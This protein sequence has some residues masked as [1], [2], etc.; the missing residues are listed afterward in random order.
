VH[1]RLP[2]ILC[3]APYTDWS[4]HSARQ[5]TILQGLRQRGCSVSYVTC[6]GVFSDCDLLQASTGAPALRPANA[7]LFCQARVATRLAGWGMPFRWLSNWLTSD[8]RKIAAEWVQSLEPLGYI[9]ARYKDWDIGEWVRSSVHRHFRFNTLD[10]SDP[11]VAVVF[12]S[13]LYSGLLACVGLDR[14]FEEEKPDAQL[15]FNGRMAPTRIA[16]ELAKRRKIR[17]ICEERG[18]VPNRLQ[19]FHNANC[20]DVRDIAELWA[21]WQ[22]VP[23]SISE[24]DEIGRILE[25]R[26]H[27]RSKDVTMFSSGL[28]AR[29]E[30]WKTLQLDPSRPLY[31]LFSSSL[32]EAVELDTSLNSFPSQFAW[33][34]A[35]VKYALKHPEIQLVIRVHPNA[36]SRKSLGFN[37]QDGAYFEGLSR[38]LPANVR[39]VSGESKISS[40][41][42]AIAA[43]LGLVWFSSIAAEMAAMGRPVVRVGSNNLLQYADFIFAPRNHHDYI[44]ILDR[45]VKASSQRDEVS[46]VLA[47]RYAY[48]YLLRRSIPFPLVHQ[49]KWFVGEMAYASHEDLAPG[50]DKSLDHICDVFMDGKPIH[51]PAPSRPSDSEALEKE[52]ILNRIAPYNGFSD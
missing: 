42:I 14:I 23:L 12:A 50:R 22:S 46:T 29:N 34:D 5:V 8:D 40:Y 16:L 48:L 25:E 21:T 15:L 36:G 28:T 26:W 10:L 47:W 9:S 39:L 2:H 41:D 52:A 45:F 24:V 18:Y 43:T 30:I 1:R 3:F 27:G 44:S 19:L 11:E 7:C 31:A 13:Y 33:I 51:G 38:R 4:I 35:T 32:D 49:P 6:D 20:L 37:T 17:T